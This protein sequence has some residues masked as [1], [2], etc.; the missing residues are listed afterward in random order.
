MIL[1]SQLLRQSLLLLA[2]AAGVAAGIK[3]LFFAVS[4]ALAGLLGIANFFFLG[5]LVARLV[6]QASSG[7]SIVIAFSIKFFV[8]TGSLLALV[9]YFEPAAVLIGFGVVLVTTTIRG[10]LGAFAPVPGQ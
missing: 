2:V 3:G 4:L 1:P 5:R 9:L 10:A 6:A 8:V 7:L